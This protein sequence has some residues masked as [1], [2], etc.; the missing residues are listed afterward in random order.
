[1]EANSK[2]IYIIL[3]MFNTIQQYK[4]NL[5]NNITRI[6][7]DKEIYLEVSDRSPKHKF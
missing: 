3:D 4:E 6:I 7:D 1:M 2:N 5:F